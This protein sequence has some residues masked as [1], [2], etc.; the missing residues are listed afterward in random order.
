[1]TVFGFKQRPRQ[2]FRDRHV[3]APRATPPT[4]DYTDAIRAGPLK[5]FA[6]STGLARLG[7]AGPWPM[8]EAESESWRRG[9]G[10]GPG[11]DSPF[12]SGLGWPAR[13]RR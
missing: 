11:Q 12:L 2:F 13:A 5:A 7:R 3:L 4:L 1:M 6:S 10:H 8:G 9:Q